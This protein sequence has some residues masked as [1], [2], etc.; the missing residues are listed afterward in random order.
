LA[1]K[2]FSVGFPIMM[3]SNLRAGTTRI[4]NGALRKRNRLLPAAQ[5]ATAKWYE[6]ARFSS[7]ER[8][9]KFQELGFLDEKGLT[10]FDTLHEM[11]VRSCKVYAENDLFGTYQKDSNSFEYMTYEEYGD[12]VDKCRATLRDLGKLNMR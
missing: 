5:V 4:L 10:T 6:S 12:K 9:K 3:A 7:T 2:L 8:E 11:Q 1:K